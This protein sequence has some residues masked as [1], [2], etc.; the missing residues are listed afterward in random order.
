MISFSQDDIAALRSLAESGDRQGY[1]SYL[2]GKDAPYGDLALGVVTND[3]LSGQMAS[4]YMAGFGVSP[5]QA[6]VIGHELMME[7][8][9][10]RE[11]ELKAN[12][13]GELTWRQILDYHVDVLERNALPPEAWTAY[14]PLTLSSDPA[15]TWAGFLES[16]TFLHET[17]LDGVSVAWSFR[18]HATLSEIVQAFLDEGYVDAHSETAA[19]WLARVASGGWEWLSFW[20]D[21]ELG[22]YDYKVSDGWVLGGDS[23][24]DT[25]TG[26]G[27]SD[28]ILGH[29]GD[30]TIVA[31]G[32]GE[33]VYY[34]AEGFDTVDFGTLSS[35][36]TVQLVPVDE[37]IL[38]GP[39]PAVR[40][41]ADVTGGAIATLYGM[42]KI[43]GGSG[44]DR[45]VVVEP[46]MVDLDGGAGLDTL[47]RFRLG[48]A[49]G[50]I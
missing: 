40:H 50:A 14:I 18:D 43:V 12:R 13:S 15:A 24:D 36:L 1:W 42:E 6:A 22:P 35:S 47:D 11:N 49:C 34:G 37:S 7:D 31:D 17:I 27:G 8:L 39:G 28:V 5:Q 20:R 4:Y 29:E 41:T 10:Y 30:D 9:K 21:F 2:A 25:L 46:N 44:D 19:A 26:K 3:P 16:G 23:G 33:D 48:R 45:F 38:D 32:E